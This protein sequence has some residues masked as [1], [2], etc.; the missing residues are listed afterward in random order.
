MTIRLMGQGKRGVNSDAAIVI[1]LQH[2]SEASSSYFDPLIMTKC[3]SSK[4]KWGSFDTR[5]KCFYNDYAFDKL[6]YQKH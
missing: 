1:S 5:P 4:V 3:P 2:F 6:H